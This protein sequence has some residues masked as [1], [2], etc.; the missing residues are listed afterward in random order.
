LDLETLVF[1]IGEWDILLTLRN[2]SKWIFVIF[3]M[4]PVWVLR[5]HPGPTEDGTLPYMLQGSSFGGKRHQVPC[6][7]ETSFLNFA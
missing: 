6:F 5:V 4:V 2:N 7:E 1:F 3:T